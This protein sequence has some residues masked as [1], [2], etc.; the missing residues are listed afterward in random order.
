MERKILV[1][2]DAPSPG[3]RVLPYE[4]PYASTIGDHQVALIGGRA[5]CEGCN[6]VGIIAKAGGPRRI[7]YISEVA[8][9][10]DLVICHCPTPQS[11][12]ATL[13]HTATYDDGAWYAAGTEPSLAALPV[14][15]AAEPL[16]NVAA[17]KKVVDDSVTHPH[18]AEQTEHI[19]PNMTN[20]EFA[21]MVLELRDKAISLISGKRLPELARW[22][23]SD[24]SRVKDWFGVADQSVREYL[25][26]GLAACVQVLRGLEAKNFV[27]YSETAFKQ[28]G[29]TLPSNA[30]DASAGVCKPDTATHTIAIN[31]KFCGLRPTSADQDSKLSTLI[32]EVT[33]FN[34]CFESSDAV[35]YLRS[36]REA[37]RTDP[38]RMQRNA[39]S[40]AGYVIWDEFFHAR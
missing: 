33:H 9:E 8:L 14:L 1:V 22:N 15:V 5:Y 30:D 17:L 7:Q 38:T 26:N 4:A 18:E 35:Y 2:G 40:I 32:H 12:I 36:S 27:R 11:L 6:G 10:G 16:Q 28:V 13:Q 34:D 29:C 21:T 19:C 31:I 3:G 23:A 39:D 25:Q 24:R 37:A 20:K